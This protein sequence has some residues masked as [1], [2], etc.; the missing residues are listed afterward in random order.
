MSQTVQVSTEVLNVSNKRKLGAQLLEVI[1]QIKAAYQNGARQA[2]PNLIAL[3][4]KII[5][6]N[7]GLTITNF[8]IRDDTIFD[9]YASVIGLPGHQGSGYKGPE[10]Q[11]A[12]IGGESIDKMVF[13]TTIDLDKGKIIGPLANVL[14]AEIHLT[15]RFFESSLFDEEEITAAIVHEIG[16]CFNKISTLGDY[17]W[18]NYYLIE[19]VEVLLG[20][21][22]NKYKLQFLTVKGLS[23]VVEDPKVREELNRAPTEANLR[24]ALLT[25]NRLRP[26]HHLTGVE[27]GGSVM[28]EEQLA[29]LFA[30]R[31]GFSRALVTLNYK[32]DK[33]TGAKNLKSR[34]SFQMA[35][36][37]KLINV[38]VGTALIP[39]WGVGLLWL[40]IASVFWEPQRD[41]RYDDAGERSLKV[42]QDLVAQLKQ[43]GKDDAFKQRLLEDIKVVDGVI[44]NYTKNKT[45]WTSLTE[46]ISTR[47]AQQW[48]L[49]AQ[50]QTLERLFNNDLF[51][52]ASQF[53]QLTK[54]K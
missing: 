49:L 14:V 25:S 53:E 7:T 13:E 17:V 1:G 48:K 34:T 52:T 54:R 6:S 33:M 8:S 38:V 41:G 51:V 27:Y 46:I 16:H 20:N 24:R 42:K 21:K 40:T 9:M 4:I 43:A 19:G 22:P 29:D 15:S 45:W 50:E 2:D 37:A 12:M 35:E 28:R 23:E 5:K 44:A 11:P 3:I 47:K 10:T 32:L 31:Q 36:T 26:R 39:V 18:L 30:S